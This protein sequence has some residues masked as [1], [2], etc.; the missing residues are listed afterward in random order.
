MPVGFVFSSASFVYGF[1]LPEFPSPCHSLCSGSTPH[2]EKF[3]FLFFQIL[4]FFL[5]ALGGVNKGL[6][7]CSKNFYISVF[8]LRGK[9]KRTSPRGKEKQ[10]RRE[11]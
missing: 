5:L 9:A 7:N 6:K 3:F 8:M 10:G 1:I 11:G 4:P 2:W